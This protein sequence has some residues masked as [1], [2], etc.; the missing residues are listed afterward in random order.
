MPAIHPSRGYA[1]Q[2]VAECSLRGALRNQAAYILGT[3]QWETNHTMEPVKEAYWLTEN[4]RKNNLSYYPWYGRGFVQLTLK[5]N[6]VHAQEEL[7]LGTELTDNPDRALDP[8][9]SKVVTVRG[10]LEGWFTKYRLEDFITLQKSDFYNA[11]KVVNGM[12]HA[13]EIADLAGEYDDWLL[14]QG[15]GV[16]DGD[17]PPPTG[18]LDALVLELAQEVSHLRE[19]V[20][21]LERWRKS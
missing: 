14:S 15:Y 5:D 16:D 12:K 3:M 17:T 10:M 7:N 8:E 19:R 20:S 21:E 13:K 9:I 1:P 11:R 4:W 6:Y 2:I 18:E